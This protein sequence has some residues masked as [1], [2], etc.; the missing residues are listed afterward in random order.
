MS[1]KVLIADDE[2]ELRAHL[3][4]QLETRGFQ[5]T[6][7]AD[8]STAIDQ[9]ALHQPDLVLLDVMMPKVS[10]LE[11]LIQIKT[12]APAATVAMIT[13]HANLKDAV[14]AIQDGA[15]D[16]IEKPVRQDSLNA[17]IDKALEARRLVEQAALSRPSEAPGQDFV[18]QSESMQKIF[19]V[20]DRL[21]AVNTSVLIQGENGTG[22]ELVA[23]A[24]HFNSPRKSKPFVAV[25][26]G[27]IPENLVESELF[28]YEK[29]A[30][31]GA[32]TRKL[33]RFQFASGG[34]LFLDEI[35][36]LPTP[37][38]VKLLRALQDQRITPVGSNRDVK[39]DVRVIA[40]TN[41]N[42]DQMMQDGRFRPDLF[43]RLNVM[44]VHLPPLRERRADIPHLVKHFIEKFNIK[45]QRQI[46]GIHD[47]AMA[48][49]SRYGWPGNIRELENAIEHAFILEPSQVLQQASI[50][51]H[52]L[53]GVQ[54]ADEGWNPEVQA[55][56]GLSYHQAKEQFERQFIINALRTNQGR[57]NLTSDKAQIPKNTLLRKMRKYGIQ[58][59]DN[60]D[61]S[62]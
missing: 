51:E 29:G 52:I 48:L 49:L 24:I 59:D 8:G 43:Y 5:V 36:D 4:R 3:R 17:M 22:K 18:G 37:M 2:P 47:D 20:I 1:L 27:A 15:F 50:P 25:N 45:H 60:T 53:E 34:T 21:A 38:Q 33:G 61:R 46:E 12:Q 11:A 39:V 58:S 7:A 56:Q 10:G 9:A 55:S 40:A 57:I 26:C 6:E 35:G 19:R 44:P 31:T 54:D 30:F 42:L 62:N 23:R 16:Y 14:R 13:A 41:R 32:N 28:G